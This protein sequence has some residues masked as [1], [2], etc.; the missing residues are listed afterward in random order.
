MRISSGRCSPRLLRSLATALSAPR[1]GGWCGFSTGL[2]AASLKTMDGDRLAYERWTKAALIARVRK[3][4]EE[5]LRAGGAQPPEE[6]GELAAGGPSDSQP[7]PPKKKKVA[8]KIDASKYSMR[9]VAFKL[10]YLGKDFGGFEFSADANAP[11][12]EEELWNA[13]V[14]AC[15]IFPERPE[16]VDWEPWGY[17]KCGRTDRGVSAFG[18]VIALRVRSNRPLRREEKLAAAAAAT[19]AGLGAGEGGDEA[20][21]ASECEFD[22]VRD[23]LPYC[24]MLNRLLPP[25][26]RMLAWCPTT[27]ADFS[28]RYDCGGRQY[29]Y[30]FTQPAFSPLPAHLENPELA[31][32]GVAG[33]AVKGGW[34]DIEAMRAAAKKFEGVHDF[35]NFCRVDAS[36]VTMNFERRIFESDI[37]E[38]PGAET[39][40]P[41]LDRDEFRPDAA[42]GLVPP[43]SARRAPS[44]YYFHVRGHA[45]LWHQIRCMVAV[46]FL[47]GQGLEAPSIVDR[48]LDVE[49]EPRRPSYVLADEVPLVLWDCVFPR[50]GVADPT[51]ALRWVYLGE[52]NAQDRYGATGVATR[53]WEHWR[54]RKMDEI[55]SAQ[56]LGAIAAQVDG[57][58][59]QHRSAPARTRPTRW[60]FEGGNTAR[61]A[62]RYQPVLE[63]PRIPAPEEIFDREAQKKGYA[64]AADMREA[65]ERKRVA[66]RDLAAAEAE[67]EAAQVEAPVALDQ[68]SG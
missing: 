39:G 4:E 44:V 5:L 2:A 18:Q 24:R 28:A 25:E 31:A 58:E 23:E 51:R 30:F 36:K 59:G 6:G 35:R 3:L 66:A 17:S 11:S 22:D 56:L 19:Q 50:D 15:L 60:V 48:L 10:A 67:A 26:I 27:P 32:A 62:G 46:L 13:L 8:R 64:S 37:V 47:V 34:L 21:Q 57:A 63:K 45:F 33:A 49:A 38:L 7:P 68:A 43:A 54:E 40:L 20:E 52:E 1:R 9:L 16:V 14:K 41:H 55:L 65:L 29:R 61:Q 42:T 53:A 12:I